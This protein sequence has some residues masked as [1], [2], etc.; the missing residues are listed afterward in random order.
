MRNRLVKN[1]NFNQEEKSRGFEATSIHT[2]KRSPI[3]FE[4]RLN[5]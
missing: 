3:D 1:L 5:F 4:K 2:P